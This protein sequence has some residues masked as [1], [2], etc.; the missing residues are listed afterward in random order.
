L[1][2]KQIAA[3]IQQL[4]ELAAK[5]TDPLIKFSAEPAFQEHF[6]AATNELTFNSRWLNYRLILAPEANQEV[7]A[8]YH[9]F[10]DWDARLNAILTPGLLPPFAR[11]QVDAAVAQRRAM[12]SQV[13]LTI[14]SA[15]A[16]Q[17]P[18][19][20]RSEHRLVRPL[21]ASDLEYIAHLRAKLA[22]FKLVPFDQYRKAARR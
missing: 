15:K 5:N 6:D 19:K 16:G 17:T 10:C 4:K 1:S 20:V 8:R 3:F 12:A 18:A 13:F 2:T 22:D 7:V 14:S 11:L 21:T 9:E